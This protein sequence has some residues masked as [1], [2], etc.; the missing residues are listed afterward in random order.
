V[1]A[2]LQSIDYPAWALHALILIP[3][4]GGI[5]VAL[6]PDPRHAKWAALGITLA[7]FG[8]SLGL[9]WGF[10]LGT[11]SM[12]FEVSH[13][14]MRAWGVSYHLGVDGISLMMILLTTFTMPLAVLGSFNYIKEY[15][16]YELE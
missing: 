15:F 4:A 16:S 8:V 14:W 11:A 6:L 5:V 7:E 3:L 2:F 1:A 10:E 9:W 13:V 12:Q